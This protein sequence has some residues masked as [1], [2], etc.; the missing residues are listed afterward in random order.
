[1]SESK[2]NEEV[3]TSEKEANFLARMLGMVVGKKQAGEAQP[4]VKELA[5]RVSEL[6]PDAANAAIDAA[7]TSY[8]QVKEA[9]EKKAKG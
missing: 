9:E 5:K 2:P 1:M 3:H 6:G 4:D 8:S 7:I